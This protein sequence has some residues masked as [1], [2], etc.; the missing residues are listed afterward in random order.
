MNPQ[1]SL[2]D[3]FGSPKPSRPSL[4]EIFGTTPPAPA[5]PQP[6]AGQG[7]GVL[8]SL[9]RGIVSPFTKLG[10][11]TVS[12]AR[13]AKGILTG[14]DVDPNAPVG[15][16]KFLGDV[17]P[18]GSV[19][20][21]VGTGL[22]ASSFIPVTRGVSMVGKAT[23]GGLAREGLKAGAK[24]GA[25]AGVLGEIGRSQQEDATVGQTA[26]RATVGGVAG[27]ALGGLAGGTLAGVGSLIRGRIT[28]RAELNEILK[29]PTSP[30]TQRLNER[31]GRLP[32]NEIAA[33]DAGIKEATRQGLDPAKAL[34][35]KYST[36][37]DKAVMRNMLDMAQKNQANPAATSRPTDLV[38]DT[39]MERVNFTR[40]LNKQA[41][42]QIDQA[43]TALQGKKTDFSQA[44]NNFTEELSSAGVRIGDEGRLIFKGSDFEGIQG[45]E[46]AIS[47]V[48]N[49]IQGLG[50]DAYKGHQLKRYIDN[51]VDYGKSTEGIVGQ[52]ERLLKQL[53]QGVDGRLDAQFPVYN[54]ANQLYSESI[55]YL[56][57]VSRL[58]GKNLMDDAQIGGVRSGTVMRRLLGNGANRADLLHLVN[59]VEK[60]AR[61]NGL[62]S[63][64]DI[65]AQMSFADL[66]EDIFGTQA[67][68]GLAAQ[69]Q[70][71][72]QRSAT[73]KAIG[74][75]LSTRQVLLKGAE[76]IVERVRGI[77]Y[78]GR[79]RALQDILK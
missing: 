74:A 62:K 19:K 79:V 30:I 66:L 25:S 9:A 7:G 6:Q 29:D 4:N 52:A 70:R 15:M 53:R 71:G 2:E 72:V 23:W 5:V 63:N 77:G 3:I 45:A 67:A 43:A 21:A 13:Q 8:G 18:I 46:K 78:A 32:I 41:G 51:N 24:E 37:D 33:K 56:D 36:T 35:A 47:L 60:F 49:R 17:S 31:T 27:G 42:K 75:S 14:E 55:G 50:D 38:G 40:N 28:R 12:A 34:I 39:F 20:E 61:D 65:V 73:A 22:E 1:L 26:L 44:V 11:T 54:K 16:G 64:K 58:V 48:W 69:V 76:S 59:G 68:T 10:A 57:E